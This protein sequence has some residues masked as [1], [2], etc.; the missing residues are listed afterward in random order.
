[1]GLFSFKN[2]KSVVV[3]PV[4]GEVLPITSSEDKVFAEKMM[5][6]RLRLVKKLQMLI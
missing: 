4:N 5:G 6:I 2:K 1:M 3:C